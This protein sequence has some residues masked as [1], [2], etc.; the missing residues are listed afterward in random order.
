MGPPGESAHG[1]TAQSGIVVCRSANEGKLI[2][3]LVLA[4][5]TIGGSHFLDIGHWQFEFL[6]RVSFEHIAPAGTFAIRSTSC[7][8]EEYETILLIVLDYRFPYKTDTLR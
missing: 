1:T 4:I 8:M 3:A 2:E 6:P 5:R 7:K